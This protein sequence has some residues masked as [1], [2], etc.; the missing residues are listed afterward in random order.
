MAIKNI[1]EV[2]GVDFDPPDNLKKIK[3]AYEEWKKNLTIEQNT[4]VD[5]QRRSEIADEIAA[6]NNIM[7]AMVDNPQFRQIQA[8]ELKEKHV[9]QLREYI[10]IIRKGAGGTL[11]VTRAQMKKVGEKLRLSLST[12][13]ATY[14][15][16]GFEIKAP[17]NKTSIL[18]LLNDFFM[19]DNVMD[20]LRKN[21][22]DFHNFTDFK[23]YPWAKEVNNLYELAYELDGRGADSQAYRTWS[24]EE[25][26]DIFRF[27]AQQTAGANQSWYAIKNILN[28]AQMQVFNSNENKYRYNH[29][30]DIEPLNE[31]FHKLKAAPD[32]F[33]HDSYFADQCINHIQEQNGL[34]GVINRYELAAALYNKYTGLLNDPYESAK[35]PNE[36]TFFV[37]CDNC[38]TYTQFRTK[39]AA[40]QA[41]CP[42]CGGSFYIECPN[43]HKSIP[44]ASEE[45]DFCKFKL[46]E[47]RRI[48]DYLKQANEMLA[49]V[50]EAT[51]VGVDV[52]IIKIQTLMTKVFELVAKA[53]LVNANDLR[54]KSLEDRINKLVKA[55]KLRE[56]DNWAKSELP[57]LSMAPDKAVSK[58]LEIINTLQKAGLRHYKP[59]LERLRLIKPKV[60]TSITAVIKELAPAKTSKGTSI[61]NK[62][63]VT[64]KVHPEYEEIKLVC[65][66]TWQPANDLG[67]KYQLIRK[68]GGIPQ[69][70]KD[71]ELLIDKT[72]KLEYED[73]N[74]VTGLLYGYAV[75]AT[76]VET[77]SAPATCQVVYYSDIEERNL[78]ARTEDGF[79]SFSW[80]KPSNRCI[81]VR[82]LRTDTEGNSVVIDPCCRQTSFVDRAVKSKRQ[83]YYR[84]Q[85]VYESAESTEQ[86]QESNIHYDEVWKVSRKY[87]YSEGL[88]VKLMPESPPV[89]LQNV[90]Y[91]VI[92]DRVIFNWRSTGEFTVLFREIKNTQIN[93]DSL[94]KMGNRIELSRLDS[95]LGSSK[96]L[97]RAD[98]RNQICEFKLSDEFCKIAV[99][100]A[101][102]TL[103]VICDVVNIANVTPCTINM[104]KT[105]IDDGK[106]KIILNRLPDKLVKIYYAITTKNTRGKL[107]MTVEDAKSNRMR[108]IFAKKYELDRVII[109][110]SP[111]P[112]ELYLTVIGEYKMSDGSTV[113][114]EP[115]TE[116]I[117]NRPKAE[118][119]Y[120][121]EW[122]SSGVFKKTLK[123]KNCKLV[124]ET[125]A[126]Y[127]PTLY[128]A[129][130]KNGGTNIELDEPAT[131]KIR[132]IPSSDTGFLGGHQE[133]PL[134][135]AIW[136]NVAAGTVIKLLPSKKDAK[137][138]DIR[139]ARP[140]SLRVPQK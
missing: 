74:I 97:A 80:V 104:D 88:T 109:I 92:N 73:K 21:F 42:A 130:N 77:I 40:Q 9:N 15:E 14:K 110:P 137:Y 8:R 51:S 50:E 35:N 117:N 54:L 125:E 32:I 64:G 11:Q 118:I 86:V 61:V 63:N 39:E 4:T 95:I 57:S 7:S 81:G 96:V 135:N 121:L 90:T 68:I 112:T 69:N 84:L 24:A 89:E 36:T 20:D 98:S 31:L 72:E 48:S 76:R 26:S 116:I 16:E 128:L 131:I 46:G 58:C 87:A 119:V 45:C 34:R 99:I 59:V 49:I 113:F 53:R 115:D 37:R 105:S 70:N 140:D 139:P 12:V 29:S 30:V 106:L 120:W 62:I 47:M 3:S 41:R 93:I 38:H 52:Q 1:F 83:Y 33:K 133:F 10:A 138:F 17:R 101:T 94:K 114:S 132:M 2:L 124:I 65:N 85:C 27:E 19:S 28:I 67:V 126:E 107:Y 134:D 79:C 60:P 18:K 56:L 43:C 108:S 5:V 100:S 122:A 22:A 66:V 6:M 44:A 82:I 127:T 55:Q 103:G 91:R 78:T 111:P 71:G 129:Y 102:Q 25:L 136:E 123:A 23:R 75:F 13:E